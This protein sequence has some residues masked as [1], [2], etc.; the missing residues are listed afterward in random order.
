MQ[1][2]VANLLEKL[3]NNELN[4]NDA[5][6]KISDLLLKNINDKLYKEFINITL[7]RM[8]INGSIKN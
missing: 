6:N 7:E 1:D 2:T 3:Y 5:C 4:F 8:K